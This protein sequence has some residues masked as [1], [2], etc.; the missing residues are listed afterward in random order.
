MQ[1]IQ[2]QLLR[3]RECIECLSFFVQT[4]LRTTSIHDLQGF[5]RGID[6]MDEWFL[7]LGDDLARPFPENFCWD[8]LFRALNVCFDSEHFQI[9]IKTLT[10]VYALPFFS[11][12][13]AAV[14]VLTVCVC[15]LVVCVQ[16][17]S[18]EP[19]LR[20][21]A[22]SFDGELSAAQAL[23]RQAVFALVH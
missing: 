3:N 16:L 9:L 13:V 8:I 17:H 12:H 10:F 19:L 11:L 1:K 7:V 18:R 4:L 20:S 14:S 2:K 23:L 21:A 5:N 6:K 22:C 15:V